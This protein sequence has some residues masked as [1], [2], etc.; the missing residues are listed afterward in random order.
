MVR[1]EVGDVDDDSEDVDSLLDAVVVRR[2][3]MGPDAQ[4]AVGER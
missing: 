2:M 1:A 4:S 3:M